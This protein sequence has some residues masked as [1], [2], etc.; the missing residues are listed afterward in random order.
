M[1]RVE[2]KQNSRWE[3]CLYRGQEGTDTK[4]SGDGRRDQPS[5]KEKGKSGCITV[6]ISMLSFFFTFSG[7]DVNRYHFANEKPL[8][9]PPFA[10]HVILIWLAGEM[11]QERIA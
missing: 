10:E 9:L 5:R 11:R 7:R 2:K 8:G 6:R 1:E 4:P 3:G